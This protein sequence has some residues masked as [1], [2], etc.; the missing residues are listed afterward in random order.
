MPTNMNFL[1][2]FDEDLLQVR[3]IMTSNLK[4]KN[5]DVQ[6]LMNNLGAVNGKMIRAILVLIGGSFGNSQKNNLINISAA[7]EILH[8]ATLVHDDIIDDSSLRRSKATINA[9]HG[10]K[11]ALFM[12]DYLFSESYILFSRSVSQK[13]ITTIS[14]MI[15]LI[16]SSEITQFLTSYSLN[17]TIKDYLVRI[18]GK[19][20]SLFSLSLSIGAFEGNVDKKTILYLEKI[21]YYCGM[22]FQLVDDILDITTP[23]LTLGKP[24][25]SDIKKGI[26]SLPVIFEIRQ[27]NKALID[28]LE[29]SDFTTV[30]EIIKTSYGLEKSRQVAEKYTY[31][32][33]S[34][35]D[36]LAQSPQQS[37]LKSIIE[38]LLSRTF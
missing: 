17:S 7:V 15:K 18:N 8:L 9:T 38:T 30:L 36:K 33:L 26:Y 16:C 2:F 13:S 14:E 24:A 5:K 27:N 6:S 21:G 20:A 12:G 3:K 34:L 28:A 19:C 37:A 22:A 31:K 4:D 10:N 35:V 25:E 23:K 32:A 29:N 1:N 11:A